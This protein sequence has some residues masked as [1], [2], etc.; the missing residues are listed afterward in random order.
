MEGAGRD[1]EDVRLDGGGGR[2]VEE[3][4]ARRVGDAA[5]GPGGKMSNGQLYHA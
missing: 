3:E 4:R 1:L 2:A 5:H